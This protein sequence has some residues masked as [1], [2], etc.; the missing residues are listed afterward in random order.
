MTFQRQLI[1]VMSAMDA[2]CC[3]QYEH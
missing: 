1:K 2:W 3:G